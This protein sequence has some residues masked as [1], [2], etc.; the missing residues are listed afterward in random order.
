MSKNKPAPSKQVLADHKRIGSRFIPPLLQYERFQEISWSEQFIP[1]LFW[2]AVLNHS[3]GRRTTASIAVS[4]AT[5]IMPFKRD[6][7]FGW[8]LGF[9]SAYAGL[10]Q[11]AQEALTSELIKN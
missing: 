8:M 6:L 7:P 2:L 10:A 4:M 9:S 1:E 5:A 11:T 3:C